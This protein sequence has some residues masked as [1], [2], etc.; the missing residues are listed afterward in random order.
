MPSHYRKPITTLIFAYMILI[1][2][3]SC[4]PYAA[5]DTSTL[6]LRI[7]EIQGCGHISD[8][9][10][11]H[12][13]QIPGIV[14]SKTTKGFYIQDVQPDELDC[15]SEAIYVFENSYPEVLPGDRV[16]VSGVVEEYFA[17]EVEDNNLSITE[18]IKPEVK[19]LSHNNIIPDAIV[20]GDG[21]RKIPGCVID[22]DNL[23][24]FDITEDG[25]D[26]YESMESM[27]VTIDSGNVVGPR[28]KFN[29]VVIIP[30]KT[31]PENLIS[32]DM[33]LV[34]SENDP[35]P[36]RII[37]NM[38]DSNQQ[39]I[40]VGARL[41][42]PVTG[43]LDYSYGN[44]KVN[45]FGQV[46]FEN[47]NP[48]ITTIDADEDYLSIA[49]YNVNNLSRFDENAR[50]RNL[51]RKIIKTMDSPDII[52]LHEILDDSGIEDDGTVTAELTIKKIVDV[53]SDAGGPVYSYVQRDPLDGHDGGITGGNIRSVILY[54]EDK[55]ISLAEDDL[56]D[57]LRSNP[58]VIGT[59]ES[60]FSGARK[61]LAVLF[62][63]GD[64][65]VLLIAVHLTSRGADSPLFGRFQPII[66][67]EENQRIQQADLIDKFIDKYTNNDPD[68]R[69]VVAGDVNDDPWSKTVITLT[70]TTMSDLGNQLPREERY[71]Y[72]LDGN[73]IQL[74]YILTN[75]MSVTKDQFFI[76]HVNSLNDY[77]SID[78]D[79][80]PV[81]A[82]IDLE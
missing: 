82:L 72:N 60:A 74:D 79:H 17:G 38:N 73:A 32:T 33:A 31:V 51:A 14:T 53:I 1:F 16:L 66:R 52:I 45:T 7:H 76:L 8:Y 42:Y 24:S 55:G 43:I 71:T 67:P 20:I 39:E 22:D 37:L 36:E 46:E 19:I 12:V 5:N 63:K 47:G 23:T 80:D 13:Y 58:E 34:Q 44:F 3:V 9:D 78:S 62:N 57:L 41:I 64:R 11:D 6:P 4:S 29:E 2:L 48:I 69:I 56:P 21:G 61:P 40:N 28:N 54:R 68:A 50:F 77:S 65:K 15:S 35:N 26:F 75:K 49:S 18:I 81:M 27:V 10:G 30:A 70:R 59:T 25:I